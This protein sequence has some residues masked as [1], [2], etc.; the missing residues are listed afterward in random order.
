MPSASR[1]ND[2]EDV[3][4]VLSLSKVDVN[5]SETLRWKKH[6]RGKKERKGN[7]EEERKGGREKEIERKRKRE[8]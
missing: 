6:R 7:R 2:C 8:R 3:V 5:L 4:L 1:R